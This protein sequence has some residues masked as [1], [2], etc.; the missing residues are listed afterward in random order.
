M[1][2]LE[3]L[4][5]YRDEI[6]E[7]LG[8]VVARPSVSTAPIRTADGEILPFGR[9][10]HDALTYTLEAGEKL[11]LTAHNLD[12]KAGYLELASDNENS[13][14]CDIVGHLDVVPAG[15]GWASDPFKMVMKDGKLLGRGVSDDKA[16]MVACMYAIK[17]LKEAGE[18]FVNDVRLVFGLDEETGEESINYYV[19]QCGHPDV[20]FTP[21]AEFPLINGEKGILQF[22][23]AQKLTRQ[24]S[25]EG[26]RLNKFEAG[27][28]A[29]AVPASAKA[30]IAADD[31]LYDLIKDRLSQYV[32]E[33]GYTVKAKKQGSSLV[34]ESTGV[35]A[36]GAHPDKGLNAIS[37]LMDF[38]GRLQ[39]SNEEI[40]DFIA[41]Y[42]DHIGFDIHGE[43]MNCEFSDEPSGKLSFNVGIVSINEDIATLT[44]DVRY[45]VTMENGDKIFEG[46][47][48]AIGKDK[49]GIV[50]LRE[51]SPIYM[52]LGQDLVEKLI[53]AYREETGDQ[54]AEPFIEAGGTY[55][56]W[57]KNILA[58]GGIF[59]GEENVMHQAN[60]YTSVDSLVKM[61]RIY[62]RAIKSICC[63]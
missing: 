41:F 25:K 48:S 55:A 10:V 24:M 2:Y 54:T 39:F 22:E 30:V 27:S 32:L 15:D 61:A 47:E 57:V 56:K 58:F 14:R 21:D 45:P 4:D 23:L 8:E 44:I 20:G 1:G 37:I 52:D 13:L 36:H 35:A 5:S 62:A 17:A 33:T 7:T 26:L 12:N 63:E 60:E 49:I 18:N 9:G 43:R 19:E 42:N 29:N 6:I 3:L 53:G 51:Y 40:N 59:P 11:G 34:V 46:I 31:K 50:K 38:L 16:P 28:T